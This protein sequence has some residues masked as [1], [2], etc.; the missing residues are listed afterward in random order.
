MRVRPYWRSCALNQSHILLTDETREALEKRVE[1]IEE[2]NKSEK[3]KDTP[4]IQDPKSIIYT[5]HDDP[6]EVLDVS[7]KG[8]HIYSLSPLAWVACGN[9]IYVLELLKKGY[10]RIE[11]NGMC[12]AFG[13]Q[14]KIEPLE[15]SM[16][17]Y[18]ASFTP[19]SWAHRSEGT[20]PFLRSR[21]LLTAE[22]LAEAVEGADNYVAQ[23]IFRN[24]RTSG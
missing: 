20:S 8:G 13:N 5:D 17:H 15:D 11:P 22:D 16:T 18:V 12:N 9:G 14:V 24:I 2:G 21:A 19:A 10:I 1:E 6:F 7:D 4:K 23:R 3:L